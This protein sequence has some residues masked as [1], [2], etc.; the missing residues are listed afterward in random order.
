[1]SGMGAWGPGLWSDDTAADI[2]SNYREALEDGLD[3]EVA[4]AKILADFAVDLGDDD[5][6]PVVWLALAVAQSNVGRL[7][8][9]VKTR[10]IEMIDSG[11]DLRRWE[12]AD[13]KTLAKRRAVLAKTREQL[14]SEQPPRKKIR[15]PS[16]PVTDLTPG[17]LIGF[18]APSGRL[19]LLAV[20]ALSDT[21]YGLSPLVD[22]LDF[23]GTE[24]PSAKAAARLKNRPRG[25]TGSGDR[26]ADP[27]WMVH[28]LVQKRRGHDYIDH[29]FERLANVPTPTEAE[30]RAM[31]DRPSSYSS[32]TNWQT[33]LI[34]QD[35][36]LTD[37]INQRPRGFF[38]RT[39]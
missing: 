25:R 14:T 11:A 8:D 35:E 4:A 23:E 24:V 29:G 39:T 16:R 36:L 28:S 30:Q 3:D 15:K 13:A 32:W 5:G 37:R 9:D 27:W 26:P 22:L 12:T 38:R 10:A 2:R 19:Y 6:R 21:R 17:D 34:K 31:A 33:Y 20:R 1:M 7:T 18:R